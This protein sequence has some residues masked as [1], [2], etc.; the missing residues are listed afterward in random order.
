MDRVRIG[1]LGCGTI[2]QYAHIFALKKADVVE[3]TAVCEIADDLLR[4][5]SR[6]FDIPQA[7]SDFEMFLCEA[8]IDAVLIASAD[9]DHVPQAIRSLQ[10]GKHVLVEKPLGLNLEEC[11]QLARVVEETGLKL[12][13]G[14]MKRFDPGIEFVHRF[15][16]E[17]MGCRL[18]V[19]GW[20]CDTF[21]KDEIQRSLRLPVVR[22]AKQQGFDPAFKNDRKSY[23]LIT[24]G[25]HLI[26]TLR[27]FGGEIVGLQARFASKYDALTW[28]GV[29]EFAD[30]ATGHFE[31][32][33]SV[34]MDWLEGF[35]VHG[36]S[37]SVEVKSF[38][39]IFNRPSEVRVFDAKRRA[40]R[41][42]L[43]ADSDAY[44]RQVEAFARSIIN[45]QPA[46]PSVYDGIADLAV[47]QAIQKSILTGRWT[48]VE[49]ESRAKPIP[50]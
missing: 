35:H 42:P 4:E 48:E 28:H 34:K 8:E 25:I 45:C 24:H 21:Y 6:R 19:S 17:D 50:Q 40:Y 12:Q 18:S 43:C 20:Y 1:L 13:V 44:E 37:G 7:F 11:R 47:I 10:N 33:T 49:L 39:P 23:K 29:L 27:Y 38:L 26:D 32:T 5:V 9:H 3:L 2:S 14:N 31:L 46:S 16:S 36:E 30:G 15:I 22:S 41:A